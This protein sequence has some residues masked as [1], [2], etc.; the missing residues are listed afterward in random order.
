MAM[1]PP[2]HG[3]DPRFESGY[4]H[5]FLLKIFCPVLEPPV[6]FGNL[7][8]F[9]CLEQSSPES[10]YLHIFSV[11]QLCEEGSNVVP[12]RV[13]QIVDFLA[14]SEKKRQVFMCVSIRSLVWNNMK[15]LCKP[16]LNLL[17]IDL[18][19]LKR[20]LLVWQSIN[21]KTSLAWSGKKARC[22]LMALHNCMR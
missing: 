8:N 18:L 14:R 9:L 4:P 15:L 19:S 22:M 20:W 13:P 5:I 17:N 11:N 3:V 1:T 21:T 10:R 7:G 6:R 16:C 2:L 12:F